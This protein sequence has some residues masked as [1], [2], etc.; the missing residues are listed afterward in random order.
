MLILCA[1]AEGMLKYRQ[2]L[3]GRFLSELSSLL[4]FSLAFKSFPCL[5]KEQFTE[6]LS[7]W[8]LVLESWDLAFHSQ[9][10]NFGK[11]QEMDDC[12]NNKV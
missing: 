6:S 10:K 12:K 8:K 7:W 11:M 5:L 9:L 3:S 4:C 2:E 1:V